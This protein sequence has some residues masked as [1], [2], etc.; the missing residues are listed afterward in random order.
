MVL[1]Q[2]FDLSFNTSEKNIVTIKTDINSFAHALVT[3]VAKLSYDTNYTSCRK[4]YKK[5][6]N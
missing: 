3:A 4:G 5:Y 2:I 1:K 6:L